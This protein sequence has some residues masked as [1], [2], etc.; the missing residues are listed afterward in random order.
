VFALSQ[1]LSISVIFCSTQKYIVEKYNSIAGL[2]SW[3]KFIL[4]IT[5]RSGKF[6]GND[7]IKKDTKI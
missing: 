7:L 2:N 3:Q 4:N 1:E 6:A 5:A